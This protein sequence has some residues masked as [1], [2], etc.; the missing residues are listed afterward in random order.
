MTN[1]I[2]DL[3]VGTLLGDGHIGRTGLRKAFIKFEQSMKKESYLRHLY[4][5]MVSGGYLIKEPQ[6]SNRLDKRYNT[7]NSSIYFRTKSLEDFKPLADIFLD[8]NNK[9]IV[10]TNIKEHLTQRSLAY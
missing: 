5:I 10:P 7:I 9:K 3:L 1:H 6:I 4:E 8:A 2:K